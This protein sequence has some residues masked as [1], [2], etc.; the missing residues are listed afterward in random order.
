MEITKEE[1][2]QCIIDTFHGHGLRIIDITS[3]AEI[4]R[5]SVHGHKFRVD[6]TG[7]VESVGDGVLISDLPAQLASI[8]MKQAV[9]IIAKYK[10]EAFG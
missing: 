1:L 9:S 3:N 5:F 8:I 10:L 4:I 7:F 6:L 2:L